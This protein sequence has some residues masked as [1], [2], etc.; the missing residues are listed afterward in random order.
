[1]AP[2]QAYKLDLAKRVA[3][4]LEIWTPGGQFSVAVGILPET[5]GTLFD[6]GQTMYNNLVSS[7]GRTAHDK[8]KFAGAAQDVNNLGTKMHAVGYERGAIWREYDTYRFSIGEDEENVFGFFVENYVAVKSQ[9]SRTYNRTIE[10]TISE[11]V[12]PVDI[13]GM[14][15]KGEKMPENPADKSM[16]LSYGFNVLN[17]SFPGF[18]YECKNVDKA[19][20]GF[21]MAIS[22]GKGQSLKQTINTAEII[23][24]GLSLMAASLGQIF[25]NDYSTEQFVSDQLK[26]KN[27]WR[28]EHYSNTNVIIG[29]AQK[30]GMFRNLLTG[31]KKE[32]KPLAFLKPANEVNLD[33]V[34]AL[35]SGAEVDD[36][37]IDVEH[38]DITDK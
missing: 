14:F 4:G 17:Q 1:M 22:V 2:S 12:G 25:G 10:T 37:V 35:L 28:P 38:E 13:L 30:G 21:F 7:L 24:E 26:D 16:M 3:R 27:Y 6:R 8:R 18:V 29:Y 11:A 33:Q 23:E 5:T 36:G 20:D 32:A 31:K 15:F 9:T 19:K 34:K